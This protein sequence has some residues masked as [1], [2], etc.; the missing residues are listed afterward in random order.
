[1]HET[2]LTVVQDPN[3]EF[4]QFRIDDLE[5]KPGELRGSLASKYREYQITS[6][7]TV[8]KGEKERQHST[9]KTIRYS[10]A[11]QLLLHDFEQA[12]KDIGVHLPFRNLFASF[13]PKT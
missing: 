11:R 5:V 6:K 10:Q 4:L 13:P 8:W 9:Q 2:L 7:V 3:E 1:M 12:T